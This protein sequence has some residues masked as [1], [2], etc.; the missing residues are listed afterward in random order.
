MKR[1]KGKSKRRWLDNIKNDLSESEIC[2]GRE[3]NTGWN[4]GDSH[5]A[6]TP[7]KSGKGCGRRRW[8]VILC[9]QNIQSLRVCV[10]VC[11]CVRA[12]ACVC[13]CV[14]VSACARVSV[15]VCICIRACVCA[16]VSLC[17]CVCVS[18]C[19]CSC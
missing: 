15:Y 1:R 9:G 16:C 4:G 18:V 2:Q 3:R 17:Q 14:C 11:V 10:C 13:V 8:V 7:H 19:Y 6:S 5:E 12:C